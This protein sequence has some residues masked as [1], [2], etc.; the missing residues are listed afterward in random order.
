VTIAVACNLADGVVMGTDSAVTIQGTYRG[1]EGVLKVYNDAE[2]LFRLH[3]LPIAI[4]TYGLSQLNLRTIESY[5]REFEHVYPEE[6]VVDLTLERIAQELWAFFYTR[7]K[8]SFGEA[9]E[10][11]HEKPFDEIEA[12][13]KPQLGLMVGGFSPGAY[14]SELWDVYVHQNSVEEGVVCTR[15]EGTFGS[16]WRGQ[17][18]GIRRFHKGFSFND[19]DKVI[20]TILDHFGNEMDGDLRK[21]LDGVVGA[22]EYL[23]PWGGMPLQE[24]IDYTKFCLDIMINQTKFVIGAPTCGGNVR[25][26][27]VHRDKGF[28]VVTDTRFQVRPV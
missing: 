7:Y 28:Q 16:S 12:S 27:V 23:I 21:K 24:G 14:L 3:E 8:D 15:P 5:I 22:A 11:E 19:L 9:L 2:K 6:E 17:I 4:A 10:Q 18:E 13:K 25:I 20:G 26:A 1:Q